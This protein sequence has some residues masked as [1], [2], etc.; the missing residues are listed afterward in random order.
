MGLI[1]YSLNDKKHFNSGREYE[2]E[3]IV[4]LIQEQAKDFLDQEYNRKLMTVTPL[5]DTDGLVKLI[6]RS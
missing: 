3:R 5:F 6:R 2:R 1:D 4:K